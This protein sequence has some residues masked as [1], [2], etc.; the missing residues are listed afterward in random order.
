MRKDFWRRFFIPGKEND[1]RPNSLERGAVLGMSFLILIS[2]AVAN[3][4]SFLWINSETLVSSILPS[5]IVNYTNSE[6]KDAK[7]PPLIESETLARAA[8]MKAED[9]V[10][11]GYFAHNSP[12]GR[13]P[14]YW[15]E[16]VSYNYVNAGENL[17]VHFTD[18]SDVVEAWMNSP[19]HRANILNGDFREIGVGAAK[20][21]YEGFDTVFVVQLFGTEAEASFA[22]QDVPVLTT[23]S[24]NEIETIL[25][26][27]KIEPPATSVAGASEE[28]IELDDS[29]PIT[30]LSSW[31]IAQSLETVDVTEEGTVFYSSYI[32][33][34]TGGVPADAKYSLNENY[35]STVPIL[36][37]ATRPHLILQVIYGV[38]ALF[39]FTSLILS[40]FIEINRQHPI[41]LAYGVGL[42]SIM[43][44][45]FYIHLKVTSGALII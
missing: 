45:L 25:K 37:Y 36:S 27:E 16:Q 21:I 14:W 26:N 10:K 29:A 6:R 15:F 8:Q 18:S 44:L 19:A 40:I 38:V 30:D 11:G 20:G 33:T 17:A 4:H 31:P 34:S 24:G 22:F 32:S 28:R 42:F 13:T 5:V 2:F 23:A 9:M 43:L 41:Q 7:L 12:D 39:V 35:D 1:Y 3:L